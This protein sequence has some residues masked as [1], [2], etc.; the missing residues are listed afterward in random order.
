MSYTPDL[1]LARA[2]GS[3]PQLYI[4]LN[5]CDHPGS[6][7]QANITDD[8]WGDFDSWLATELDPILDL[9]QPDLTL[10][11]AANVV[12]MWWAGYLSTQYSAGT[13]V[14]GASALISP[15][16]HQLH[17]DAVGTSYLD[18]IVPALS[19]RRGRIKSLV[20]YGGPLHATSGT[21]DAEL[22]KVTQIAESLNATP[23]F[24]V[25]HDL[26]FTA[27]P[28]QKSASA[29]YVTRTGRR[30]VGEGFAPVAEPKLSGWDAYSDGALALESQA[31]GTY[32][33]RAY[34]DPAMLRAMRQRP[35]VYVD[36]NYSA[37]NRLA[38][39]H[40][41][42]AR[43]ADYVVQFGGLTSA[44][45]QGLIAAARQYSDPGATLRPAAV[46]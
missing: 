22:D 7:G 12:F 27:N 30:Q 31:A 11:P 14:A 4:E 32:G 6:D 28:K 2:A 16:N 33:N 21:S 36:G 25:L 13:N 35:M 3:G 41:W 26:D 18:Q 39:L 37:A 46:S 42:M 34:R 29:R 15:L 24:D 8:A 9:V 1:T 23:A 43:G 40:T 5:P 17:E 10:P 44:Q 20:M 45:K 38:H 19:S